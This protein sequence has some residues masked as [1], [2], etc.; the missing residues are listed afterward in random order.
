MRL[1]ILNPTAI[2]KPCLEKSAEKHIQQGNCYCVFDSSQLNEFSP[3]MLSPDYWQQQQ[4]IE[5]SAQGRG[6]TYFIKHQEQHWV[7]RHYY[8]GGLMG[9]LNKDSYFF[10]GVNNTRAAKEFQ[11]LV[12][13]KKLGLPAPQAIAYRV[14]KKGLFYHADLLSSRIEN[15]QDLVAILQQ[16]ALTEKTWFEIG[17]MIK[18][19]HQ[20]GIYH[21]DLN[22]HNILL[23]QQNKPWLIDFDRGEQ[24]VIDKS[25]QENNLA[26]LLRSFKKEQ[27][28]IK[29]FQWQEKNW[30]Q[31]L[32]GYQSL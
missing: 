20:Q 17:A 8:R 12:T 10:T 9:K 29:H 15:A 22:S 24:R 3:E 26:R 11:L 2:V 14:I 32:N 5:G 4:A 25:W 16:Q 7:L 28:K 18:C 31:L 1:I 23:D 19:F 21:H 6:T 27:V 30:Q 13:M